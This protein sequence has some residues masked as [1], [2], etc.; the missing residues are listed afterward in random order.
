[1]N[2]KDV[3]PTYTQHQRSPRG[4]LNKS[5]RWGR[6][7]NFGSKFANSRLSHVDLRIIQRYVFTI[8]ELANMLEMR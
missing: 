3:P 5:A 2:P 6:K 4:R 8:G 1:M 7:K